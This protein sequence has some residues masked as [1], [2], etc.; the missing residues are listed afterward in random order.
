MHKVLA[1][2]SYYVCSC[3]HQFP[4]FGS[5]FSYTASKNFGFCLIQCD[6]MFFTDTIFCGGGNGALTSLNLLCLLTRLV[7][8]KRAQTL[9]LFFWKFKIEKHLNFENWF[10]TFEFETGDSIYME[11]NFLKTK[12][13]HLREVIWP[14][15]PTKRFYPLN[16]SSTDPGFQL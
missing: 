9:S 11:Q 10:K 5:L 16:E 1:Y 3:S 13:F 4:F 8:L 12:L 14:M 6:I 7:V 2:C 15:G